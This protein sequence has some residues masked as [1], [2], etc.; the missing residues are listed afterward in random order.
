MAVLCFAT[1]L[2]MIHENKG[3]VANVNLP[4]RF[5]AW[6]QVSDTEWI[7]S[8]VE[9]TDNKRFVY[10]APTMEEKKKINMR[11]GPVIIQMQKGDDPLKAEGLLDAIQKDPVQ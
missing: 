2:W 3:Y 4:P 5:I 8:E 6:A 10:W 9:D 7:I 1:F 11:Q